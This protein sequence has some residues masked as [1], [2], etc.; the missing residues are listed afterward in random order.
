M[1]EPRNPAYCIGV[2]ARSDSMGVGMVPNTGVTALQV[3]LGATPL[4]VFNGTTANEKFSLSFN[5]RTAAFELFI[6][7]N[8]ANVGSSVDVY[9][10]NNLKGSFLASAPG[11]QSVGVIEMTDN[12]FM[13]LTSTATIAAGANVFSLTAKQTLKFTDYFEN[14]IPEVQGMTITY[15]QATLA[16]TLNFNN[17]PITFNSNGYAIL[18]Y[19]SSALK[20]GTLTQFPTGQL[21]TYYP[22]AVFPNQSFPAGI[23]PAI[24]LPGVAN[25]TLSVSGT[26]QISVS[27]L[28]TPVPVSMMTLPFTGIASGVLAYG[29]RNF[30]DTAVE[31]MKKYAGDKKTIL[32][33]FVNRQLSNDIVKSNFIEETTGVKAEKVGFVTDNEIKSLEQINEEPTEVKTNILDLFK[34]K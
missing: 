9:I 25:S 8:A 2:S 17:T 28:N 7:V 6:S 22:P 20:L 16:P 18:A 1:A 4:P 5:G 30:S 23:A 12:V 13:S 24:L 15:D 34:R 3:T 10:N 31:S 29:S 32:L 27:G 21:A 33:P 14:I 19:L 11:F 26:H